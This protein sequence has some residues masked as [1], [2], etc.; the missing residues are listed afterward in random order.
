[1]PREWIHWQGQTIAKRFELG[2]YLGGSGDTAVFLTNLGSA[3]TPKAVIKLVEMN[4]KKAEL[5]LSLWAL[6][7]KLSHPHLIPLLEAGEYRNGEERGVYAV[8]EYADE[9]LSAILPSR[10]LT[11]AETNEILSPMLDALAY[12]HAQGFL[13]GHIKPANIM[14]VGEQLKISSDGI[15]RTRQSDRELA[16]PSSYLPPEAAKGPLSPA[17]DSWSLGVTLIEVLTQQGP[18]L[19]TDGA[20]EA[21]LSQLPPRFRHIA[22]R[23]L[24]PDPQQ[25]STLEEIERDLHSEHV[26]SSPPLSSQPAAAAGKRGL[27]APIATSIFVLA[28]AGG[29]FLYKQQHHRLEGSAP[30]VQTPASLPAPAEAPVVQTPASLP[31][32]AEAPAPPPV[33]TK[34]AGD[35][36]APGK[37]IRQVLPDVSRNALST[38]HGTIRVK[39][40]VGV[41]SSGSVENARIETSGPSQYFS[42]KASDAARQWKFEAPLAKGKSVPSEWRL[43][44][45]FKR[46]GVTVVSAQLSP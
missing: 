44:F 20:R 32:P 9:S 10:S 25:R 46:G 16:K 18:A 5:Q 34:A 33:Q 15:T 39:V 1:M 17:A 41:D 13:H 23:C 37:G 36:T 28:L 42:Q 19:Q 26:P 35:A 21:A 38:V 27:L 31:A 40:R 11:T 24:R 43:D 30:A 4:G 12:I 6:V 3:S 29:L 22:E 8:M 2:E 7:K 45:R 14:A